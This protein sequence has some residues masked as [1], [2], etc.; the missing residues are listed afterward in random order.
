MRHWNDDYKAARFELLLFCPALELFCPT[1]RLLWPTQILFLLL[2]VF[3]PVFKITSFIEKSNCC[4]VSGRN[5]RHNFPEFDFVPIRPNRLIQYTAT[6]KLTFLSYRP[7]ISRCLLIAQ[8]CFKFHVHTYISVVLKIFA[9]LP[10]LIWNS[11]IQ[12]KKNKLTLTKYV[13]FFLHLLCIENNHNTVSSANYAD[14]SA[15]QFVWVGTLNVV[16]LWY[17]GHCLRLN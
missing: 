17:L 5:K 14:V 4:L 1:L 8:E 6:L 9:K 7:N 12:N 2:C 13:P 3:F 16:R 10:I 11:I 15:Y